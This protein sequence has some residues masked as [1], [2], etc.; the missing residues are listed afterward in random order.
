MQ[1]QNQKWQQLQQQER[2]PKEALE[3]RAELNPFTPANC[4]YI[5]GNPS[6]IPVASE[7]QKKSE[8]IGLK[9]LMRQSTMETNDNLDNDFSI[10]RDPRKTCYRL[11]SVN[12]DKE[13]RLQH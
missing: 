3:T 9:P 7:T 11:R 12:T 13:I 1:L 10:T 5:E 8:S 4:S 6:T 2:K